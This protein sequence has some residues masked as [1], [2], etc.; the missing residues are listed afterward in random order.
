M[1]DPSTI[2]F[3]ELLAAL[4]DDQKPLH[5][6]YLYRLS[7]LEAAELDMFTETWPHLPLWRRQALLE[8][9]EELGSADDLLSFESIG[10]QAIKDDDP[11]V[12]T[13]AVRMLWE[14]ENQDLIPV[15]LNLLAED[16]AVDVRAAAATALGQF[17]YMGETDELA[18]EKMNT[19]VEHLLQAT[20]EDQADLVRRKALESLGFSSRPEIPA[21]IEQAFSTQDKEWMASA[22]L[23]MGRSMDQRWE[24]TVLSM[25]QDRRPSL[26][27]EAARAAGEMEITQAVPAL[28]D[29][30]RDSEDEV[31]LAAIWSLSQ[32]GGE[33]ARRTLEDLMLSAADDDEADFLETA[34]DNLAFTDGLQP[35]TLF[36]YPEDTTESELY[37]DLMEEDEQWELFD[38][39]DNGFFEDENEEDFDFPENADFEDDDGELFD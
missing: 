21:L 19:L 31:R 29:L 2:S 20:A 13:L 27:A 14:F 38:E 8:D 37:Q 7:D 5:P 23:A 26:R 18:A 1:F 12:R 34:L 36:E 3:Q 16:P 30:T 10:R 35:F 33:P 24:S 6:R 32:I 25:L 11:H 39:D 28:I 9:L 15:F 17:V 22:L 4:M